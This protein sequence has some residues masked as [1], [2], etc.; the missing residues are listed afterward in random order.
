MK[1]MCCLKVIII[2]RSEHHRTRKRGPPTLDMNS[3]TEITAIRSRVDRTHC[4]AFLNAN[5]NDDGSVNN[6]FCM[7]W[8]GLA[9]KV[10]VTRFIIRYGVSD[11]TTNGRGSELYFEKHHASHMPEKSSIPGLTT[12]D[13]TIKY[14]LKHR[15]DQFR[16]ST[17]L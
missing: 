9:L 10:P 1:G 11:W 7:T 13:A 8:V 16:C 12:A 14:L 2:R 15:R 4:A 17:P 6:G 3:R 5:Q